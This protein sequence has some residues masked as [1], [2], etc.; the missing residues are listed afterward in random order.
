MARHEDDGTLHFLNPRKGWPEFDKY[1][2]VVRD[3][4]EE[5]EQEEHESEGS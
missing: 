3:Q 4:G 5:K 2:K 1:G